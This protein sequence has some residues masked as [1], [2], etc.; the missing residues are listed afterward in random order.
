LAGQE[1]VIVG[2]VSAVFGVKGWIKVYSDTEP[3]ENILHYDP[4][5]VRRD[6][7]WFAARVEAGQRHGKAV[8]AKLAGVADRDEAVPLVGHEIA[9]DRGQ[10]APLEEDEYYWV[11]LIGLQV[12]N[13]E[14]QGLG[15]VERMIATGA[16]DVMIVRGDRE[17]L[18]PF[19]R[20]A[21]VQE[22]DRDAKRIV[23]DW[24]EDY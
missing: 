5:Y 10:L 8:I 6:H 19:V 24:A 13:L 14:G 1:K 21:V 3:R 2:H 11:D 17:R 22:V 7:D 20:G 9:I 4:W 23:V 18:I 15:S 16:N 12:V